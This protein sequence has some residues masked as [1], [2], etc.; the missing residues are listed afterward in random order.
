MKISKYNSSSKN[1]ICSSYKCCSFLTKFC[2][3]CRLFL[4]QL[5]IYLGI[6]IDETLDWKIHLHDLASKYVEVC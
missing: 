6:K 4:L 3:F 2:K 1:K 5:T